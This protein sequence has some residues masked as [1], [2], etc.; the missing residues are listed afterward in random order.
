[1]ATKSLK[2]RSTNDMQRRAFAGAPA[3]VDLD[4]GTFEIVVTTDHPV[5]TWVPDPNA[6]PDADGWIRCI[7]AL[8]VLPAET[9]DY[10][11]V[12][13]MPLLDS[14]DAHSSIDKILGRVENVRPE[15]ASIVATARLTSA[16]KALLPDIAA[17]FYGQVSAGYTVGEYEYIQEPGQP[18]IARAKSWTLHEASLVAVGADPNASVRSKFKVDQPV[19]RSADPSQSKETRMELEELVKAAED[20][21]TAADTAIAAVVTAADEGA[22]EEVIERAKAIRARAEE[23]VADPEKE[24]EA[25]AGAKADEPSEEDK[26]EAAEMERMRGIAQG[27]GFTETFEKLRSLGSKSDK[28]RSAIEAEIIRNGVVGARSQGQAQADDAQPRKRSDAAQVAI[29]MY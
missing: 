14:H 29:R 11:R 18:L 5:M 21:I 23:A 8:E 22:A 24:K 15:G 3:S 7:D 6:I 4:A 26:K 27:M 1:M 16:R 25:E 19:K 12:E 20:A 2:L 9:M 28:I 13:R 17:G 10:S